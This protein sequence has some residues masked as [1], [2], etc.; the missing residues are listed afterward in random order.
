M[1]SRES[2]K[3]RDTGIENLIRKK[4]G[5]N[6]MPLGPVCLQWCACEDLGNKTGIK[7]L[8]EGDSRESITIMLVR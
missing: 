1:S 7:G 3:R 4:G 5:K 6:A 2:A 8:S